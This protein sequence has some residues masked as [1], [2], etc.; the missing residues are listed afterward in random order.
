MVGALEK[1]LSLILALGEGY[2]LKVWPIDVYG[3]A[4]GDRECQCTEDGSVTCATQDIGEIIKL[5]QGDAVIFVGDLLHAGAAEKP[6]CFD[7]WRLHVY[8]QPDGFSSKTSGGTHL[9]Q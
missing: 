3:R 6:G 8:L 4:A 1:P 7:M 9:C 2:E 5:R